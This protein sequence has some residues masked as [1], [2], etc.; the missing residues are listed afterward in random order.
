LVAELVLVVLRL[1]LLGLVL[2][3]LEGLGDGFWDWG[4]GG[5]MGAFGTETILV[6]DVGD[7]DWDSIGTGVAVGALGDLSLG[8]RVASV[9]QVS[10]LLGDDSISGLIAVL[11]RSV[12]VDLLGLPHD[13]D[14]LVGVGLL[15]VLGGGDAQGQNGGEYCDRNHGDRVIRVREQTMEY[16]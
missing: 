2:D 13:G 9:L 1:G 14:E 6:S 3:Q 11:V 5:Q 12:M 16:Y 7:G 4:R 15:S 10:L 8:L